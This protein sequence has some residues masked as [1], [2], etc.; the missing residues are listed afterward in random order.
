VR[1]DEHCCRYPE[2]VLEGV[3][4]GSLVAMPYLEEGRP[5]EGRRTGSVREEVAAVGHSSFGGSCG[6]AVRDMPFSRPVRRC[7]PR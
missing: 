2:A 6:T 7:P 1:H 4:T 5:G 3:H